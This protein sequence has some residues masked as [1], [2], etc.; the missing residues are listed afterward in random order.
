MCF[1]SARLSSDLLAPKKVDQDY[2]DRVAFT[3]LTK[4][5]DE[6]IEQYQTQWQGQSADNSM[7]LKDFDATLKKYQDPAEADKLMAIQKELDETKQ[8]MVRAC[9]PVPFVY[10]RIRFETCG[11][12]C[13]T[14]PLMLHSSVE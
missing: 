13:S 14:K 5:L 2:P 7:P 11:P 9:G 12:M 3:L 1:K 4:I 10:F 8:I 6:F